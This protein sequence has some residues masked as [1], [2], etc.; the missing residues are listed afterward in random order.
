MEAE[1]LTAIVDQAKKYARVDYDDDDD[2]VAIMVEAALQSMGELIPK[3]DAD[4]M[5]SRQKIVLFASVKDLYDKRGKY[6]KT[7]EAMKAAASTII[8]SEIYEPKKTEVIAGE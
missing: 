4:S 5:T 7:R 2:L 3:F 8:L 6:E 1:K